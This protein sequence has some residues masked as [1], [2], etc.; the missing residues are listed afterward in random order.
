MKKLPQSFYLRS[1][2]VSVARDLIGKIIVSQLGPH[3]TSGR[4]VETEAYVAFTDRASHAYRG[5]RTTRNEHMYAIGGTLYVYICYGLHQ[6]VNVVT[7]REGTPDA[8]LIR[9]IEPLEGQK[10]MQQRT[11]KGNKDPSIT[12]GP[13][14]VGKA[15]GIFKPHSG[16][17]LHGNQ[18]YLASDGYQVNPDQIGI[19]SRIGVES[20]AEDATLPYRFFLKGNPHVSRSPS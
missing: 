8:V 19:S 5:R 20:A 18:I 14:N 1:E 7:N 15:L 4:I 9:G 17:S 16:L 13:G 3:R 2:V 11:G 12:R 10:W 6:M